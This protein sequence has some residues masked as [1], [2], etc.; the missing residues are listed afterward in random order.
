MA[1]KAAVSEWE[2]KDG[3][4][5]TSIVVLAYILTGMCDQGFVIMRA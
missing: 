5:R 1:Y 4:E 3:F 2:L